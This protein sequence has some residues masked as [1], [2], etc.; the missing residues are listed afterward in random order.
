MVGVGERSPEPESKS[1]NSVAKGQESVG[2]IESPQGSATKQTDGGRRKI[3]FHRR[4]E[5]Q[6]TK[7]AWV[8]KKAGGGGGGGGGGTP[9]GGGRERGG[10]SVG[11]DNS[12]LAQKLRI[13][14]GSTDA[15]DS[16]RRTA[17]PAGQNVTGDNTTQRMLLKDAPLNLRR[18]GNRSQKYFHRA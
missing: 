9:C 2:K 18:P 10:A 14:S 17:G 3:A 11:G 15:S 8:V 13:E 12:K 16:R 6:K 5:S 4:D 1:V 7:S